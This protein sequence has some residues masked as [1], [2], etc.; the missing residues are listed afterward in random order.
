MSRLL[1]LLP[2][3]SLFFSSLLAQ[4]GDR[5]TETQQPLPEHVK[6]PPAPVLTP[7]EQRKTFKLAPGF[8]AELV[9]ADPLV[10]DPI[11]MQFGPDGR[12]WV[13]EMR[14]FMPNVD[15]TGE[16]QPVG[17]VAVLRDTDADG[18]MDQRTVFLEGLVLPRAISL[19]GDGLLVGE[20]TKLWFCRDT[21]GDGKADEKTEIASDF[22]NTTNPEHNANGLMWALDNWIYSANYTARFRY[23]GGGKFRREPTIMRGQW[24]ITQDDLGRLYYNRNSDPLRVDLVPSAYARRNPSFT[25]GGSNVQLVPGNLPVYPGR[26]TPGIN[27]GYRTLDKE[28]KMQAV[29]AACG[30]VIYRGALFPPEFRG[31]AFIAEPAGNLVKRIKI[32]AQ[33][34]GTLTA[35]N[36]YPDSEFLTSTDERF[37]P[38]NLFNGPDGALYVVDMYRGVIQHRIYVTSFL[39]KQI[40]E[41]GLDKGI[42]L[43]RIWRIVPDDAPQAK[44]E[45]GLARAS[46]AELIEKLGDPNGWTRDTAQRLLVEKN[47]PR[48]VAALKTFAFSASNA[49]ARMHALWTLDGLQQIDR[50]T[51]LAALK[52][53]DPRVCVAALRIAEKF[54]KP[55]V[56]DEV[57]RRIRELGARPEP[58][59]KLQVAFSLGEAQTP[60]ADAALRALLASA[61]EVPLLVDAVVSGIARREPEFMEALAR[62]IE[63]GSVALSHTIT[64]ATA[65]VLKSTHPE[66]IA[67]VLALAGDAKAPAWVRA[68]VLEGVDRFIPRLSDGR[69]LTGVLL[70]E[71]KALVALAQKTGTPEAERATALLASLRWPGKPGQ[72]P[73]VASF[74]PEQKAR[75]EKG[76]TQFAMLCAACHQPEGQGMPGLAPALVN[77]RWVMGDE[78]ILA[79]IV[80]AGKA[81]E[82]LAM[83]AL[84]EALDDEAI[85][86]VLTYVRNAWNHDAGA[87]SPFVVAEARRAT[88]SRQEPFD[89][90]DLE[91]LLQELGPPRQRRARPEGAAPKRAESN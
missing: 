86:S 47:D 19:V 68:A 13:L 60:A 31:D 74:T 69:K 84:R 14:G 18:R 91:E 23:E 56:D 1:R 33:D 51:A 2:F 50:A 24:G 12:L 7:E 3:F 72:V 26:M 9:A 35:A 70:A 5:G 16:D 25:A 41:R 82:N 29:T 46:T 83:P 6:V 28:F 54:L 75:F 63:T 81:R 79:R 10:H 45:L 27:R 80:L 78:R 77:S 40:E 90:E 15:G 34:D 57:F 43:G 88:A 76:K 22:G 8:R 21:D 20:P 48:G 17:S 42:G 38:V 73:A 89:D 55:L 4:R 71:P 61:G 39:R 58:S 44:F 87:V 59:V 36:A 32:T 30:P 66:R 65:A 11:A 52:D 64:A 67:R 62:E 53:A 37:R 49:I 85:A